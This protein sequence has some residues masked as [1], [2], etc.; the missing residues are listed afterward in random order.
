M[1]LIKVSIANSASGGH[2]LVS[3]THLSWTYTNWA[4]KFLYIFTLL[5][6]SPE[7]WRHT[8]S[9]YFVGLR[10][11][12]HYFDWMCWW[13]VVANFPGTLAPADWSQQSPGQTWEDCQVQHLWLAPDIFIKFR[14]CKIWTW[15]CNNWITILCI[16]RHFWYSSGLLTYSLISKLKIFHTIF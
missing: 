12:Q 6:L 4:C 15:K 16:G 10:I 8:L 13:P 14:V 11:L 3:F 9:V 5:F 2:N 7:N 1:K